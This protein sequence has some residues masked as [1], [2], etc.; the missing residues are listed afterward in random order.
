MMQVEEP[1]WFPPIPA[2]RAGCLSGIQFRAERRAQEFVHPFIPQTS[3]YTGRDM[4]PRPA[5]PGYSGFTVRST[6]TNMLS[7]PYAKGNWE[8]A[9]LG[10]R[11][12]LLTSRS[13]PI[14]FA[15]EGKQIHT[16]ERR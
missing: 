6:D 4:F 13:L 14:I 3:I 10:M 1:L 15:P 9:R 7:R 5:V 12:D 2:D 8:A 16:K 11:R